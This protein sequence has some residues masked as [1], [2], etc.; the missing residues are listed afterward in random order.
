[1]VAVNKI[2]HL[3]QTPYVVI[4]PARDEEQHIAETIKSVVYQSVRPAEW[5]IVD[6]GSTDGTGDIIDCFATQ[7]SWITSLHRSNR[8]MRENNI[9]AIEAFCDGYRALK[10]A[11]WEFLA[12]LDADL[13]LGSHYFERCLDEF[14]KG[15]GVGDRWRNA[16]PGRKRS[17]KNGNLPLFSCS[18]RHKIYRRACWDAMGGLRVSPGWDT[19]DE[20]K[21]NMLGWRTRSFPNVKALHRRPTGAA[22]GAWR[23]AVKNGQAEYFSG[24]HPPPLSCS[25]SA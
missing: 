19:I 12:N 5:V 11:D 6:D 9:G 21:A 17:C 22:D 15:S 13:S 23:D 4:T 16:P 20:L 10:C 2:T 3:R 14:R 25:S 1:M 24:Y 7:H 8:G 18:R